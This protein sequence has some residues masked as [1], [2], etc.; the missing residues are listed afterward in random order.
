[1][2]SSTVRRAEDMLSDPGVNRGLA[3]AD[4][5]ARYPDL[6][7]GYSVSFVKLMPGV[8]SG[9]RSSTGRCS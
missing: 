3:N 2:V 4:F 9:L 8:N 5:V 6:G 1:M 7:N